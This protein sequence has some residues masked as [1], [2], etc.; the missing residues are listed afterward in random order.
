LTPP[1]TLSPGGHSASIPALASD[2]AGDALACWSRYDG[3]M[4]QPQCAVRKAGEDAFGPATTLSGGGGKDRF[5]PVPAVAP[6]GRLAVVYETGTQVL[7][8]VGSLDTG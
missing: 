6:N 1:R 3:A 8:A 4:W 5:A 7:A 2:D